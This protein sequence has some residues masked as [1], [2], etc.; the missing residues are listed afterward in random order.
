MKKLIASIAALA[1]LMVFLFAAYLQ[2]FLWKPYFYSFNQES[3]DIFIT[4][5]SSRQLG[6]FHFISPKE[7]LSNE[8]IESLWSVVEESIK[9]TKLGK[10]EENIVFKKS[11]SPFNIGIA[12]FYVDEC[13]KDHFKVRIA[14][15]NT[16]FVN[17]II[18]VNRTIP[19]DEFSHG[20][21]VI[22]LYLI[23]LLFLFISMTTV[24]FGFWRHGK[25]KRGVF[26]I[27]FVV[28]SSLLF[29]VIYWILS[30]P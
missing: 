20:M 11:Y 4:F 14:T 15:D 10:P 2:N 28:T 16:D 19:G 23:S 25:F 12:E 13:E 18:I 27:S 5:P 21:G 9:I 22:L 29:V 8:E 17:N 24:F 1:F 30:I 26:I 7:G 3:Q 6:C